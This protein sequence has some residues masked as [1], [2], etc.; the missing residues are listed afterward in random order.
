MRWLCFV[1]MRKYICY[2]GLPGTCQH[3]TQAVPKFAGWEN[4][5][6]KWGEERR[7]EGNL[8]LSAH[9]SVRLSLY[10]YAHVHAGV[11]RGQK[12]ALDSLELK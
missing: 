10:E 7:E 4:T 5:E 6:R 2:G 8:F 3:H 9:P 11:H 1:E 12:K